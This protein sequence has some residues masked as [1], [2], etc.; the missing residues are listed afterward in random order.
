MKTNPLSRTTDPAT[1]KTVAA[2]IEGGLAKIR[3][4]RLRATVISIATPA[5]SATLQTVLERLAANASLSASRKRD[6]RSAVTSFAKLRDQAPSAIPL[7]LAAIRHA[8]D[9]MEPAW[10][11]ISRKRWQNIRSGVAA[12]IA[13]SGLR[14]MLKTSDLPLDKVWA[15]LL[16]RAP[17]RIRL[18]LM[19]FGRWA[20]LHGIRPEAVNDRTIARFIAELEA[21]TLV[22]GLRHVPRAVSKA[23]NALVAFH[24]AVGLRPVAVPASRRVL[25]RVPWKELPASIRADA[26]QYLTWASV[27]DPLADGARARALGSQTL[28]LQRDHI[29]SAASAAVAAGIPLEK[30]TSLACLVKPETFRALLRHRWQEDGRKLSAY[31]HGIAITLIAIALEWVKAPADSIATLKALRSK[32]GTLP[33][34]LTPKNQNLLRTFDDPRLLADLVQLPDRVWHT[35]RRRLPGSKRSFVD[36]QSALAID[37]LIHVPLR[38]QNLASLKF[39]THLHWPQGR[40]KPAL[41]SIGETETKNGVQLEFEIPTALADRLR[42]FREEIAPMV[43]GERPETIFVTWKGTPKL[44]PA[45]QIAVEKTVLRYLGVKITPHQFRHLAA[46]IVL[47]SNPGAY[48]LVRQLLGHTSL[49]TTTAFYA[50]IDTRRA[51]RAHADLVMRLRDAQSS[52]ASRR[53]APRAQTD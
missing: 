17:R 37:L 18:R 5:A 13:A 52:R 28:R 22:R 16:V 31:T 46:K 11:K 19:R 29:H 42:A 43:I 27:P 53:R 8:L 23:W 33:S 38:I 40:H 51:G 36:L 35:A 49:R 39:G 48:E 1:P 24:K 4:R 47:D 26:D 50:G 21:A 34:G 20:S 3:K 32:L 25:Q 15:R 7:D 44:P 9:H 30:F 41:L 12:A 14:P 2:P 6:L 10:A 45:V